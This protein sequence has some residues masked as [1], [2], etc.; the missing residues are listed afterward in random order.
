MTLFFSFFS[1]I[2]TTTDVTNQAPNFLTPPDPNNKRVLAFAFNDLSDEASIVTINERWRCQGHE[3]EK[4]GEG[5]GKWQ[6][7]GGASA[8]WQQL[9]VRGVEARGCVDTG[10]V[11]VP[12]QVVAQDDTG[13]EALG[14]DLH[15][16]VGRHWLQGATTMIRGPHAR[17]LLSPLCA[18]SLPI[19]QATT[20]IIFFLHI[21]WGYIVV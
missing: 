17:W 13:W 7:H 21:G 3:D 8:F 19:L 20:N 4:E 6:Q 2:G 10:D 12:E 18:L 1:T 9:Y 15:K 11:R 5:G 16:A 14:T